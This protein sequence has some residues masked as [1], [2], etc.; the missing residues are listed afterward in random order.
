MVW[1][2]LVWFGRFGLVNEDDFRRPQVPL[3]EAKASLKL[4]LGTIPVRVGSG[5]VGPIK[6][7][8]LSQFNFNCNCL[9]EL[10]L[11]KVYWVISRVASQLKIVN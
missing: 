3:K 5:R 9:L 1:F 4:H 2:G 8:R 10:S 6:I 11:A 7:I